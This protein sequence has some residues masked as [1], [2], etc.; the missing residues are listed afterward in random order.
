[1]EEE[2]RL[3]CEGDNARQDYSKGLLGEPSGEKEPSGEHSEGILGRLSDIISGVWHGKKEEEEGSLA[4]AL[5]D[6]MGHRAKVGEDTLRHIVS[7]H[8]DLLNNLNGKKEEGSLQSYFGLP[9]FV[10]SSDYVVTGEE[11]CSYEE[12]GEWT[13][14]GSDGNRF[15]EV[16]SRECEKPLIQREQCA[17]EKVECVYGQ[18]AEWGPCSVKCGTGM[19]FKYRKVANGKRNFP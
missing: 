9:T 12:V 14:C 6:V 16:A 17:G 8:G 10:P 18:W 3:C 11:G 2:Q 13:N 15:R 7:E 1:M 19:K 5:G 4:G